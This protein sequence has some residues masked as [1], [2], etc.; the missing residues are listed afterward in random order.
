MNDLYQRTFDQIHMSEERVRSLRAELASHCSN[1]ETE[2]NSMSKHTA[3]R[4]STSFLIAAALVAAMSIS[5]LACGVYYY[6]TYQVNDGSDIPDNAV[7]LTDDSGF[8]SGGYS[9]REEDGQI[10]VDLP[11]VPS[12]ANAD[13]SYDTT[14]AD[15]ALADGDSTVDLTERKPDFASGGY[16]YTDNNGE[17]IADVSAAG[18]N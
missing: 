15:P 14:A 9:Y 3:F 4:R 1:T 11:A 8:E 18:L 2:V 10:I 16:S 6:V 7:D 13:V 12:A 17:I 5:A